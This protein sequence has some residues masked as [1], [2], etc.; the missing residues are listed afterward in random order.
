[1]WFVSGPTF[2]PSAATKR[3]LYAIGP[4]LALAWRVMWAR[5]PLVFT[6][7]A[8]VG[9]AVVVSVAALRA[10][11]GGTR[12]LGVTRSARCLFFRLGEADAVVAALLSSETSLE[13][14]VT[15]LTLVLAP[16]ALGG[17]PARSPLNDPKT[18]HWKAVGCCRGSD[19]ALLVGRVRRSDGR[20]PLLGVVRG[21]GGGAVVQVRPCRVWHGPNRARWFYDGSLDLAITVASTEMCPL[22]FVRVRASTGQ[23][24][25][26]RVPGLSPF[27]VGGAL[28]CCWIAP[29]RG[30]GFEGGHRL[31]VSNQEARCP[32]CNV[33]EV[34]WFMVDV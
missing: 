12:V 19:S 14:A 21:E 11:H 26:V 8:T 5:S 17:S 23:V 2:F 27:P 10:R 4:D 7:V 9:T 31:L 33:P 32:C 30:P 20:T 24:I 25:D 1:V 3:L 13:S 15:D 34:Q 22:S 16:N 28:P 29:G 6:E 18:W